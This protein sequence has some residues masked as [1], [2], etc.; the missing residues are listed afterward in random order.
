MTL[1]GLG[2]AIGLAGAVAATQALVTLLF[3]ITRLDPLTYLGVLALLAACSVIAC[4][5]PAS[6]AA[7][8]DP[9]LALRAE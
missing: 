6:R 9:S 3:G 4:L 2:V 5:I 7:R 8:I 1:T